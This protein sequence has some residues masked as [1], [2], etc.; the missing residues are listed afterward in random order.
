LLSAIGGS[1]DRELRAST[2]ISMTSVRGWPTGIN[3]LA[4]RVRSA[5]HC[6]LLQPAARAKSHLPI[7]PPRLILHRAPHTAHRCET[8]HAYNLYR[9][10]AC[11]GYPRHAMR[12]KTVQWSSPSAFQIL[13]R[14]LRCR[15][16]LR[17]NSATAL[18]SLGGSSLQMLVLR[19]P[20]LLRPH[21]STRRRRPRHSRRAHGH[22]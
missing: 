18:Q 1:G 11:N 7:A 21:R 19:L 3:G 5:C 6:H 12:A 20:R 16:R 15:L 22:G 10:R 4:Y 8:A 13:R 17:Q 14:S 2:V 9:S